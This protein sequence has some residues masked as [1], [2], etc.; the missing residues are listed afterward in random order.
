MPPDL[1]MEKALRKQGF[2]LI[3]GVD[4]VGVGPLAGPV[5]AAAIILPEKIKTKGIDDS[6][7]LSPQKRSELFKSII[8][9]A[10]S[11]GVGIVDRETIDQI[12]ILRASH[13]ALRLAVESLTIKPEYILVDGK[14]PIKIK[15]PQLQ[16]CGGDRKCTSIAAASIVAKVLRDKIMDEYDKFFPQFGFCKNKGYGTKFHLDNLKQFGPCPIHRFSFLPVRNAFKLKLLRPLV[17]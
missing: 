16:L 15:T 6:K 4:E 3:A 10:V 9:E 17:G 13:L 2:K 7:K 5:L 14:Y 8:D 11:V 1:R 12:N